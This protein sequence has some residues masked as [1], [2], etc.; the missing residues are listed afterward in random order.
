MTTFLDLVEVSS[1]TGE[2]IF[3]A[4]KKI[5]EDA[6]L[7]LTKCIGLASDGAANMV[8]C[9]NSV[10]SRMK[11]ECPDIVLVKCICHSLALCAQYSFNCLPSSLA[12]L[13]SEI[14]SWFA[15]STLRRKE[16]EDLTKKMDEQEKNYKI[17]NFS[18][19]ASTIVDLEQTRKLKSISIKLTH[20][21]ISVNHEDDQQL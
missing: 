9:K 2:E 15:R 8:G 19:K 12:F 3:Q 6:G 16:Y 4:V 21:K 17:F 13:L 11:Q 18:Q 5:V 1:A 14:P 10:W 20:Q 7:D